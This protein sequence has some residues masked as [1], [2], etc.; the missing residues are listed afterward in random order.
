MTRYWLDG[1][2]RRRRRTARISVRDHGLT[3]GDG[4]FETDEGAS[5]G[6][7]FGLTRHL[8]RLASVRRTVSASPAPD[9]MAHCVAAVDDAAQRRMRQHG[10]VGR[11]RITVTVGRRTLSAPSVATPVR[12]SSCSMAAAGQDLWPAAH[13]TRDRARGPRN[14]RS[15]VAGAQDHV[16]RRERRRP[17]VARRSTGRRG[18]AC[19]ARH[20]G[21]TFA[22]GTG[23]ATSSWSS[24]AS[25]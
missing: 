17:R 10:E 2:L 22:E 23:S 19:F 24:T 3:V 15:A 21:V 12:P 4:V 6:S 5:T 16:V 1:A 11:L 7:P 9:P 14:E 20:A 13:V 8:D 18:G 25:C